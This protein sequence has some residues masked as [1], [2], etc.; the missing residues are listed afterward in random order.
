MRRQSIIVLAI[1][2]FLVATDTVLANL[3]DAL[4][5]YYPFNGNANDAT[6][7]GLNGTVYAATL[8]I[9]RFDN[10]DSAYNFDGA[11]DYIDCGSGAL[12]NFASTDSFTLEAWIKHCGSSTSFNSITARHDGLRSTFNYA[13]GVLDDRF[14][15]IADQERVDSR[16]LRANTVLIEDVWYHVVGVY[17]NKSMKVYVNGKEE[18]SGLFPAGGA[19]DSN[20]RFYIGRTG[21]WRGWPDNRYF[22]GIIDEVVVYNRAL[23]ESEVQDRY[24][25][26]IP[27]PGA[28]VLGGI[29]IAFVTWL[30]RRRTL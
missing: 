28:L 30:H 16:W 19:G 25:S 11:D 8:T 27:A 20:A 9:D 29:G 3:T 7:N 12:T 17:D 24:L 13:I 15:L 22:N 4:M 6:G 18:G 21:S 14:V 5:A 10:P 1:L 26:V 2:L 23:T